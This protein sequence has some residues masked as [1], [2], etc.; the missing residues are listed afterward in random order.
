MAPYDYIEGKSD[1]LFII[2]LFYYLSFNYSLQDS[3]NLANKIDS[4]TNL[5]K[6]Y[7]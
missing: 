4:E 7:N 5:Y 3:Y 1:L 2:S 6:F